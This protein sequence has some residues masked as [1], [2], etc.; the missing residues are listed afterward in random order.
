MFIDSLPVLL[1]MHDQQRKISEN[2]KWNPKKNSAADILNCARDLITN[3][4]NKN[5]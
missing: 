4:F 3:D 2:K 5:L 1:I